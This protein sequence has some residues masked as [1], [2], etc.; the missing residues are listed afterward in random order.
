MR[1]C[2]QRARAEAELAEAERIKAEAER[3]KAEE[4]ARAEADLVEREKLARKEE[5]RRQWLEKQRLSAE[6]EARN[7][8]PAA[9]A[10]VQGAC[11]GAGAHLGAGFGTDNAGSAEKALMP[12][13]RI[14]V[15]PPPPLSLLQGH[16]CDWSNLPHCFEMR[17]RTVL[18]NDQ[19]NRTYFYLLIL[20]VLFCGTCIS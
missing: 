5:R 13:C 15:C 17:A 3:A 16:C 8:S 7:Y 2:A 19:S 6:M 18:D 9:S 10:A 11:R 20:Q 1:R 14:K 4:L 12:P